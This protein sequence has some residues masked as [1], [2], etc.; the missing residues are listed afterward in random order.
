M[1]DS[2][3]RRTITLSS[4]L[5]GSSFCAP[6]LLAQ[7]DPTRPSPVLI[8]AKEINEAERERDLKAIPKTPPVSDKDQQKRRAALLKQLGDDFRNLQLVDNEMMGEVVASK[9]LDCERLT[10]QVS[11][12]KARASNLKTYLALP[13]VPVIAAKKAQPDNTS[14]QVIRAHL[15]SLDKSIRDFVTNPIF[16]TSKV[17]DANLSAQASQSLRSILELS[18]VIKRHT[19]KLARLHRPQR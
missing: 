4:L 15:N 18:E 12:I 19:G 10:R 16:R 13:D 17:L 7:A 1:R 11:Q 8:R 9:D 3:L 5:L 6:A 2:F 14:D